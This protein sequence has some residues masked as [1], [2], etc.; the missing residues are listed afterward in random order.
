MRIASWPFFT[1]QLLAKKLP[2]PAPHASAT[3]GVQTIAPASAS[4]VAEVID[5]TMTTIYLAVLT[6]SRSRSYACAS[7]SDVMRPVPTCT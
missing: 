1:L 3:A 4:V 2:T 6:A 5:V 7:I